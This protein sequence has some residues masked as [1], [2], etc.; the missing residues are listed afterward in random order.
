MAENLRAA[1]TFHKVKSAFYCRTCPLIF[2]CVNTHRIVLLFIYLSFMIYF[3]YYYYLLIPTRIFIEKNAEAVPAQRHI[4]SF[5]K[6]ETYSESKNVSFSILLIDMSKQFHKHK[7]RS[8]LV[9][10]LAPFIFH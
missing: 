7:K 3:Y 2:L 8:S 6:K 1:F 10:N 5:R 9:R 4:G